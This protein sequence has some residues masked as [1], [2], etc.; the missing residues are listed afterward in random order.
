MERGFSPEHKFDMVKCYILCHSNA[1][2]AERMYLNNYPERKQPSA[3][4]FGRLASNLKQY[5]G[6]VKPV[7]SRRKPCNEEKENNVLLTVTENPEISVRGIYHTTG[8][9]KSM[10]HFILRKNEFHPNK[11]RICQ[12]I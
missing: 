7:S 6:F 3:K 8:I 4:I 11:F 12:T 10:A 1:V 9:A 5:G 2:A